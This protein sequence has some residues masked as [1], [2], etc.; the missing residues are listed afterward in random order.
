MSF[1]LNG[2]IEISVKDTGRGRNATPEL[3]RDYTGKTNLQEMSEFI[4]L[5]L[6]EISQITL[7]EELLKGFDKDYI[8]AV[9]G[10]IGKR[11]EDVKPFGKI[12]YTARVQ[13]PDILLDVYKS[14]IDR[15]KVDRGTYVDLHYVFVNKN[16]VARTEQE[17]KSYLNRGLKLKGGDVVRFV[18][19]AP[20]AGKLERDAIRQAMGKIAPKMRMVK[21]KDRPRFRS[22]PTVRAPNGTYFITSRTVIRKYKFNSKIEFQW[23]NGSQLDFSLAPS[24]DKRGRTFRRTFASRKGKKAQQYAYPSIVIFISSEGII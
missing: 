16:L 3:L 4:R 17:L 24:A 2:K 15:S 11:L 10:K 23:V 19:M 14:L 13:A 8:T 21:S 7:K 6:I 18:N 9:D 12:E 22:G 20:Y 1:T 5:K